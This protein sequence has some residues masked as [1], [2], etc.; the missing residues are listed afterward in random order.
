MTIIDQH[1]KSRI[2]EEL[3]FEGQNM[4][5]EIITHERN[6]SCIEQM[7]EETSVKKFR[8]FGLLC[9]VKKLNVVFLPKEQWNTYLKQNVTRQQPGD[10]LLSLSVHS[11]FPD[12]KRS[13]AGAR[14]PS[15]S[16]D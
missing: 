10:L 12:M 1:F 13:R 9:K 15:P 2:Q 3:N 5:I 7:L 16:C 11:P 4:S 8:E 6:D 14:P